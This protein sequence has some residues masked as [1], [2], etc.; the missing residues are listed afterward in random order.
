M[1][2]RYFLIGLLVPFLLFGCTSRP[3]PPTPSPETPFVSEV[4][5]NCGDPGETVLIKG[6][7]FGDTQGSS[8]VTFSG[9]TAVVTSWSS[10]QISVLVPATTTGDVVVTVN[11]VSSNGVGFT[12]PC[13]TQILVL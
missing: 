1:R 6:A 3:I 2:K 12:I 4:S 13:G 11:G 10:T 7:G 5:P 9:V 8:F